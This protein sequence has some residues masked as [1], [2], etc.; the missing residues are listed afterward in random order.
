MLVRNVVSIVSV[1]F[2]V[3]M[4]LGATDRESTV[5]LNGTVPFMIV[6]F[7]AGEIVG[8]RVEIGMLGSIATELKARQIPYPLRMLS[9]LVESEK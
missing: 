8:P 9:Q 4:P 5:A 6:S 3:L 1:V 7:E 2:P